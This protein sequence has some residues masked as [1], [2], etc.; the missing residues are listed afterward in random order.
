M[1]VMNMY[2]F[3]QEHPEIIYATMQL[4]TLCLVVLAVESYCRLWQAARQCVRN[5]DAEEEKRQQQKLARKVMQL[6]E[7]DRQVRVRHELMNGSIL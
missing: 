2:R 1:N 4:M 3:V 7:I 6:A 5:L